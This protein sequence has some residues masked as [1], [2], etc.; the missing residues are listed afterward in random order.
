[1]QF[2]LFASAR[3]YS[4]LG[5]RFDIFFF[6]FYKNGQNLFPVKRS[7]FNFR[8]FVEQKFE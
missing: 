8:Y 2:R 7:D 1:M 5:V 6:S 4:S 3:S